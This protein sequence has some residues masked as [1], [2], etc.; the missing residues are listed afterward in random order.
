MSTQVPPTSTVRLLRTITEIFP[1]FWTSA[2][3]RGKLFKGSIVPTPATVTVHVT[4][5]CPLKCQFCFADGMRSKTALTYEELSAV[6][7]EFRGLERMILLG[8][9]PFY[10]PDLGRL[11]KEKVCAIESI[12]IFTNGIAFTPY[13]NNISRFVAHFFP[14]EHLSRFTLTLPLDPY[15][16]ERIGEKDYKNIIGAALK[17]S[18]QYSIRVK[19]NVTDSDF[20]SAGYLNYA[21]VRELLGGYHPG[22]R[23]LFDS[24]VRQARIE[25]FFYFNPVILHEHAAGYGEFLKASELLDSTEIVVGKHRTN[26]RVVLLRHLT[27]LWMEPVPSLLVLGFPDLNTIF[28][29]LFENLL[30]RI[31]EF[32]VYPHLRTVVQWLCSHDETDRQHALKAIQEQ[33]GDFLTGSLYMGLKSADRKKTA[34]ILAVY[35]PWQKFR[36]WHEAR[37]T[38]YE[39]L[40]AKMDAL[41][42]S[43]TRFQILLTDDTMK[44]PVPWSVHRK[45]LIKYFERDTVRLSETMLALARETVS[46]AADGYCPMQDGTRFYLGLFTQESKKSVPMENAYLYLPGESV[47]SDMPCYP[48][49]PRLTFSKEKGLLISFQFMKY[50][51]AASDRMLK[52]AYFNYLRIVRSI[53]LENEWSAFCDA[54][55]SESWQWHEMTDSVSGTELPPLPKPTSS[56]AMNIFHLLFYDRRTNQV[57]WNHAVLSDALRRTECTGFTQDSLIRLRE[58]MLYWD[59]KKETNTAETQE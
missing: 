1:F 17:M 48:V 33:P 32:D 41:I 40:I 52:S 37:D 18:S 54:L 53:L 49:I 55:D 10:H 27:S 34:S 24:L 30:G 29:I 16:R 43:P 39:N 45:F 57:P 58:E 23:E 56:D 8:G 12:E 51:R 21:T 35:V 28:S 26:S 14:E 4:D 50:E 42:S 20:H 47:V 22:L 6:F 31:L 9:E 59:K 46:H 44:N 2:Y 5:A 15:H 11:L 38:H 3:Q 25:E 19:F 13:L 36:N 7:D